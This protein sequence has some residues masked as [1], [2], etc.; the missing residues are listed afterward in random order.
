[1]LAVTAAMLLLTFVGSPD[2][3]S[4]VRVG[5]DAKPARIE[6]PEQAPG[7]LML[8][9]PALEFPFRLA[10]RCPRGM[11]FDSLSIAIADSRHL[12]RADAFE[13]ATAIETLLAVPAA[14]VAPLPLENV[15]TAGDPDAPR[16][17]LVPGVL[18]AH[19][20]LYCVHAAGEFVQYDALSLA[21]ELACPAPA[22]PDED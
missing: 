6:I 20:S 19:A 16:S 9:L 18:T 7:R 3:G 15:C 21:V 4:G 11:T 12:Y 13:G 14:Q 5:V 1:M 17:T 22:A 8:R 2:G 10:P